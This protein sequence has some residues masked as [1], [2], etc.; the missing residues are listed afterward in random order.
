MAKSKHITITDEGV[1]TQEALLA[2]AEGRLDAAGIAELEKLLKDDPFAQ[3]ALEGMRSAKAPA[4]M[5][6]VVTSLN[7][8]LREKTGARERKKKGIEIHWA[9]Y[10]YAAVIV[11][12]LIGLGFVMIHFISDNDRHLAMNKTVAQESVPVPEEK[13]IPLPDTTHI[14]PAKDTIALTDTATMHL[15]A[16]T[17]SPAIAGNFSVSSKDKDAQA[18]AGGYAKSAP[19]NAAAP[20]PKADM[21]RKAEAATDK[22]AMNDVVSTYKK[23]LIDAKDQAVQSPPPSSG[24]TSSEAKVMNEVTTVENA[25]GTPAA[26]LKAARALFDAGDYK[27][28]AKKYNDILSDQPDNA[29]A[30]YFGGISEYLDGKNR[31]AEKR[32]DKLLKTNLYTDGSKWYKANVLIDRGKKDEAKQLLRDLINSNSTFKDRATKKYEEILK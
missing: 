16:T 11:G 20:V 29:D 9:T 13:P 26:K 30:L 27:T 22:K 18:P 10:A 28:A 2:Y 19:V 31:Q 23:P 7:A 8:Q 5:K 25:S 32:F 21:V 6:S 15:S 12:I 17:T 1:I 3:D 14:A 4:E 24:L